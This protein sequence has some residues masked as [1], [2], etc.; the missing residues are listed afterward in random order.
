LVKANVDQR[1]AFVGAPVLE[2]ERLILRVPRIEDFDGWA[3]FYADA[4]TM[5]HL[6]GPQPPEAAWRALATMVGC[7]ALCGFGMFSVIHRES[8][9]WIGRVGPWKPQGWPGDEV[10]WGILREFEG[11][12][13]AYEASVAT[14]DWAFDVLGWSNV[15]HCIPEA[16][17]RSAALAQR[18]GSSRQRQVTLPPPAGTKVWMWGQTREQWR[19]RERGASGGVSPP[20]STPQ[21]RVVQ[22]S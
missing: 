5:R 13:F 1:V 21:Q 22:R 14:I 2:T 18:L 17:V 16:N 10:G 9:R 11:Q 7:W 19:A 15:I 20:K 6:D 8:G 4:E 3:A 12:G